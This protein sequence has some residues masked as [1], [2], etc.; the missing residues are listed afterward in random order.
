MPAHCLRWVDT[1]HP[2]VE[3]V[4][5]TRTEALPENLH[6]GGVWGD[7]LESPTEREEMGPPAEWP[8]PDLERLGT[9]ADVGLV[10]PV[11]RSPAER[12]AGAVPPERR[13]APPAPRVRPTA[14]ERER[15]S[16]TEAAPGS[17]PSKAR[18][19]ESPPGSAASAEGAAPPPA[20][21]RA[22]TQPVESAPPA[23]VQTPAEP[24]AEAARAERPAGKVQ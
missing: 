12:E 13:A 10:F 19:V 8:P 16:R 15:R 9:P 24:A 23:V 18:R 3:P 11:V 2:P 5:L 20:V 4:H 21:E 6:P 7:L 17:P 1:R 22:P 14:E